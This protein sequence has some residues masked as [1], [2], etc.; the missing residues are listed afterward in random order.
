MTDDTTDDPVT[1]GST[2]RRSDLQI[3]PVSSSYKVLGQFESD[4]GVGVLGQNDAS[5]GTPIGVQGAVPN[6]TSDGFGL[7][8]PHDARIEGLLDTNETDF[9]VD[10]GTTA[11]RDAQNVVLG[12]TSNEVRDG[13]VGATVGGGGLDDGSTAFPNLVFDE[14][15]TIGGGRANQAGSDDGDPTTATFATVAG[16]ENNVA[17]AQHAT[18]AGGQ[19]NEAS[20]SQATLGGGGN[21][22]ASGERS[23]LS[24]GRGNEATEFAATVAGG[25]NCHARGQFATAGGGQWNRPTGS[26]ST[27]AGGEYNRAYGRGATIAGGGDSDSDGTGN[28]VHDDY[29]TIGGGGEN[30]AGSD[31]GDSTTAQFATVGGG[32][33]NT[34]SGTE[35]TVGGG[36][37][38]T[39]SAREATV[40]GGVENTASGEEA[41]VGGG[42]RNTAS[43]REATVGGGL[44]NTASGRKATVPG[45]EFGAAEDSDSFVWNDG[46]RYHAIPNTSLDGLSSSTAV[47]GESVTGPETFSVSATG[48]VRFITGSNSVTYI[49]G[50]STGWSTTSTRTAKT[51]FEP[52]DTEAVVD[53]VAD[54]DVSTWE[55]RDDE[56]E[57]Q[58]ERHIGPVAEQFHD[59][60]DVGTSDEHINSINA[61][62]VLFAAVQG[63]NEKL[64]DRVDEVETENDRLRERNEKLEARL[65]AVE[66]HLDLDL[67]R[68]EGQSVPAEE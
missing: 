6:N 55:Y 38:N 31:D 60:V 27:I 15:G 45:G 7:A 23:T 40:G 43:A 35:A 48:G 10:A 25:Q 34:A 22:I 52:V 37:R 54:M 41:T 3:N 51:N 21:N 67:D 65:A 13:A 59:I 36:N 49:S 56:G 11:T 53:G 1:D 66:D 46:T 2:D 39:A 68:A 19:D 63:I 62:G 47:N 17:S 26:H 32:N 12:H 61:D 18:V 24:G 28:V 4:D 44:S 16:G 33:Q 8:T 57:G 20:A 29:G 5:S 64:E 58:G 30:Q 14:Y 50:G 9:V 42:I